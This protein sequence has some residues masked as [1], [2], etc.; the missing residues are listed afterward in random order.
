MK[1]FLSIY[2]YTAIVS[3]ALG[4]DFKNSLYGI[5]KG[6]ISSS[7]NSTQTYYDIIKQ[8]NLL[9][10]TTDKGRIVAIGENLVGFV[11]QKKDTLSI[12]SFNQNGTIFSICIRED[13]ALL[14][15]YPSFNWIDSSYFYNGTD[16]F[17][18]I[19][20]Q[21]L[22]MDLRLQLFRLSKP[23]NR[24]YLYDFLRLDYRFI[25]SKS[26]IYKSPNHSTKMYLVKE[27]IIEVIE[28]K[29]DWLKIKYYPEK[30]GAWTGKTIE[31]WIK[32][33]DVE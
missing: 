16:V 13:S 30:N 20:V 31:G 22:P 14:C 4:Q 2:V 17:D 21:S 6:E 23:K 24:N 11:S 9:S 29:A 12:N 18:Y 25:K 7:P 33:S 15:N 10:I 1:K 3:S 5:W 8:P 32:K 28:N 27:D 26:R 19:K